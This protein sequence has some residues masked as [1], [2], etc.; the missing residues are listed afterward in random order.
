M[1]R[2]SK[3][4]KRAVISRRKRL[5]AE[6]FFFTRALV[7]QLSR[8]SIITISLQ[9]ISNSFSSTKVHVFFICFASVFA[10]VSVSTAKPFCEPAKERSVTRQKKYGVAIRLVVQVLFRTRRIYERKF[11]SYLRRGQNKNG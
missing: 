8:C 2:Y 5:F 3:K 11:T 4:Q 6:M 7:T 1:A 10:G 9:R